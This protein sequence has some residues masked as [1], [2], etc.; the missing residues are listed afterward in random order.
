[1]DATGKKNGGNCQ[2]YDLE[3][4]SHSDWRLIPHNETQDQRPGLDDS[5]VRQANQTLD[6]KS[7]GR[8]A[9]ASC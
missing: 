2:Q 4:R 8:F 9:A 5:S 7:L 1:M 3:N 6:Q